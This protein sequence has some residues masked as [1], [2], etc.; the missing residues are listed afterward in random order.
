[1]FDMAKRVPI[2]IE[3]FEKTD[4]KI[5][6]IKGEIDGKTTP[7][8]FIAEEDKFYEFTIRFAKPVEYLYD[9]VVKENP[10]DPP[11]S[12]DVKQVDD[13]TLKLSFRT[14]CCPLR[15]WVDGWK[16]V[17]PCGGFCGLYDIAI[18]VQSIEVA[19]PPP[20]E[21]VKAE[22]GW[23]IV[24]LIIGGILFYVLTRRS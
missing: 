9:K 19:A 15:S 18:Y 22:L 16:V 10:E 17:A 13:Y 21:E 1:M 6:L 23:A 24:V 14:P 2:L 7:Y 12:V 20:E 4:A 8:S 5:T 3:S 11:M